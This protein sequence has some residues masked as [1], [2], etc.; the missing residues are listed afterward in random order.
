MNKEI[1]ARLKPG[2]ATPLAEREGLVEGKLYLILWE[3]ITPNPGALRGAFHIRV[4]GNNLYPNWK[5]SSFGEWERIGPDSVML[6][7]FLK[8]DCVCSVDNAHKAIQETMKHLDIE[9][10]NGSRP[11]RVVSEMQGWLTQAEEALNRFNSPM[12]VR[13]LLAGYWDLASVQ[14]LMAWTQ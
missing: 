6:S 12:Q 3:N 13:A 4:N 8:G 1:W 9:K 10:T 2:T 14:S 11:W 7:Q 5:N